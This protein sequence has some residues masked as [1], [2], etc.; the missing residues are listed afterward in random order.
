MHSCYF[1]FKI[2]EV[3][4]LPYLLFFVILTPYR[5]TTNQCTHKEDYFNK[6]SLHYNFINCIDF[7][8]DDEAQFFF[9][10]P[11]VRFT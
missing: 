10:L 6:S 3:N 8:K 2:M 9:Y 1:D 4:S 5:C 7:D 11:L